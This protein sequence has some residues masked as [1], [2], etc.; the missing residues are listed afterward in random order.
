MRQAMW[1]GG[2]QHH[3]VN[4]DAFWNFFAVYPMSPGKIFAPPPAAKGTLS[5]AELLSRYLLPA[6]VPIPGPNGT[7]TT[8]SGQHYLLG[9]VEF[10]FGFALPPQLGRA[11]TL[12]GAYVDGTSAAAAR[13]CGLPDGAKAAARQ[14]ESDLSAISARIQA[15]EGALAGRLPMFTQLDPQRLPF[16][17]YT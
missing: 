5:E 1:L 12:A 7:A 10:A 14:L 13:G 2:V 8:T 11:D 15:R 3:A 4:S 17:T 16:Y 6:S 9:L